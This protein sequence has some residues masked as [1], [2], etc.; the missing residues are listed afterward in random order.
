M[1]LLTEEI[2]QRLPKLRSQEDK[3]PQDVRVIVKFFDPTGS[4][5]WY[6]TEG[7]QRERV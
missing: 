5:T 4:W 3:N 1:K 6:V 2:I 7:E